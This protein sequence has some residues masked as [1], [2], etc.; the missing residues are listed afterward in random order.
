M[1]LY[2]VKDWDNAYTNGA[3]IAGG[4]AWPGLWIEA[5]ERFRKDMQAQGQVKF[6]LRYGDQPRNLFDL[7]LPV[8]APLGLVV[9]IHGG[10]WVSTDKSY[11]SHLAAGPVAH[12]YAVA[13]PSYTL[14]PDI[15]LAGITRE[16]GTAIGAAARMVAGPIRLV[17][18]SAGGHLATRMITADHPLPQIVQERIAHTVSLSGLHDLRPLMYT[19]MNDQLRIDEA[20]AKAESPAL[21][22]PATGTRLTCWVGGAER[23]EFRRQSA[24]LA[25]IWTG[26]GAV[27]EAVEEPDRH[28]FNVV[29]GL[30][31]PDHPLTRTLLAD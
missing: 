25:N 29:D 4:E 30:L 17:G 31:Q 8:G 6:D 9:L 16:I 20:E 2:R 18:H 21:L 3:N 22:R 28:H 19:E 7:F 26:L 13:M 10:Y 14:C 1:A 24:L 15:R 27:T 12:G 23:A 5:A 11:W